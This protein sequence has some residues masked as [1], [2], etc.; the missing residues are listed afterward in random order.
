MTTAPSADLPPG[1]CSPAARARAT[2][3]GSKPAAPAPAGAECP[4]VL[5]PT[6][7]S[8]TGGR[9]LGGTIEVQGSVEVTL[10]F[11]AAAAVLRRPV[12]LDRVPP[13]A[14]FD[15]AAALLTRY[16]WRIEGSGHRHT[17]ATP[18]GPFA[19]TC[20]DPFATNGS[21]LPPYLACAPL[22][23]YGHAVMPAAGLPE[24]EFHLH[25]QVFKHFGDDISANRAG[26]LLTATGAPACIEIALPERLTRAATATALIRAASSRTQLRLEHPDTSPETRALVT[27]LGAAGFTATLTAQELHL[28]PPPASGGA[29]LRWR[30]P[31]D[32]AETALYISA[33]ASTGG[34][35]TLEGIDASDICDLAA[36]LRPL[37][38]AL[39]P[40][41]R[42]VHV[43]YLASRAA[44][45]AASVRVTVGSGDGLED[46]DPLYL[47]ALA[48][49]LLSRPGRHRLTRRRED[50]DLADLAALFAAF[51]AQAF[52]HENVG[53]SLTGPQ[54]L[55]AARYA[56]RDADTAT[57]AVLCALAARRTSVI[58]GADHLLCR[59]PGA[60]ENLAALGARIQAAA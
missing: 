20:P 33:L 42:G 27:M 9:P 56:A 32:R 35:G 17:V 3:S 43:G 31:G 40:A 48:A 60:A 55:T 30:I 11:L 28:V 23:A 14:D 39:R 13:S 25:A 49:L 10:A 51:G 52:Y 41:D 21:G 12:T 59:H 44:D 6:T 19:Q 57:A 36:L 16:G 37:G 15:R 29:A 38:V 26:Y 18:Y 34:G 4:A 2:G 24:H 7:L 45:A 22:A 5:P 46:L 50:A 47:P 54:V 53:V 8:I 1:A 58:T